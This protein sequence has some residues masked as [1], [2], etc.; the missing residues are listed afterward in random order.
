[1][2]TNVKSAK[3]QPQESNIENL[4]RAEL[5]RQQKS[6][7]KTMK[8]SKKKKT[9]GAIPKTQEQEA[10]LQ[11]AA[12]IMENLKASTWRD[13]ETAGKF[14]KNDKL[15]FIS[16]DML[17]V[18]CDIGSETHYVRAVDTRG[19]ELSK[20][21]FA[22]DNNEEGFH[23]VKAWA[24]DL[25]ARNDKKQIVLGLEPTGHY[26]FVLAAW[27]VSN[28][29]S[30]VQVNPYAVKQTKE[31]E[32]NSQLKDDR[33]DP[34]LIANLVKDGNYGMPYLPEGLYAELRRLAM[35]RDQLSED[36]IRNINRLHREIKIYFPEYKDAF[37]K[38]DGAFSIE[39]LKKAP[40]P[41][42]ILEL[43]VEGVR[44]IWHDSKLRGRGYNKANEIVKLAEGSVGLKDGTEA[45]KAAVKWFAEKI[46][47]LSEQLS[48]I[49]ERLQEKCREIPYAEN[50]LEIPGIGANILAG[51]L[52]EMGD[53]SRFDDVKEIQKLSGLG[54][55]ACSSGKHKG[56]T[57][58]SHRGRKRL[59]YWLFQAGK[60]AVSHGEE[61]KILH[62]YYTTRSE[63]PL[64]KMQ[65]LI[66]IACKILR[67]IY[68]ILKKGTRYDPERMLRDIILPTKTQ[69]KAA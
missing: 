61:F 19:R 12:D 5:R 53:I 60:S 28:G 57:K 13:L 34:K 22:F 42:D 7:A 16:E 63:N 49:E 68:T 11:K 54:L 39:L 66:V 58:I 46:G 25:A 40:F 51:I 69:I 38:V 59:R 33:K 52:S 29:I 9:S 21:P 8:L 17:I 48:Q 65:S 43:G 67:V 6:E 2:N 26:W 56:M 14:S 50:I 32:D 62:A 47:E 24:V 31:L 35:F 15:T 18:G 41:K 55:V 3:N 10:L 27:M 37:V 36:R 4:T 20:K 44:N 1:M 45:G 23:R 30:V 64:K